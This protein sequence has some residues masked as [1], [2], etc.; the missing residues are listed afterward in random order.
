[1]NVECG[2]NS[3]ELSKLQGANLFIHLSF[4]FTNLPAGGQRAAATQIAK[5]QFCENY[6]I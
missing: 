4:F 2:I 3:D 6:P 1:M 5:P